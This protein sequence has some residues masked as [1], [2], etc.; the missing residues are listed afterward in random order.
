MSSP[1]RRSS[2]N[3]AT[4]AQSSAVTGSSAEDVVGLHQQRPA[5]IFATVRS[6]SVS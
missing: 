5:K 4:S 6:M 1:Q 3:A 2:T